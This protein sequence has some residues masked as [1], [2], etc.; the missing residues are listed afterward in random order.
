MNFEAKTFSELS[1][2]ELYELLSSRAKV[3]VGEQKILYPDPD[4]LDYEALHCFFWEDGR[5]VACLRGFAEPGDAETVHIGR[6]LSLRRGSGIGADLMQRSIPA[7]LSHFGAKRILVHAQRAARGFYERCGF[8]A[9]SGEFTEAG[10]PHIAM[11]WEQLL[12]G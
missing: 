10:I 12:T 6:V 1:T 7:L 8:R 11:V 4:G 5:A 3:F 2:A 9:I